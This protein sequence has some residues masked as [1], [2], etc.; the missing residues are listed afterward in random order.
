[1]KLCIFYVDFSRLK[2]PNGFFYAFSMSVETYL[3]D[4]GLYY[5][6]SRQNSSLITAFFNVIALNFIQLF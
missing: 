1:M 6:L 2:I 4:H 5:K 3:Y